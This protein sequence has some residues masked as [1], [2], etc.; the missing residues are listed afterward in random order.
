MQD[1]IIVKKPPLTIGSDAVNQVPVEPLQ[2]NPVEDQPKQTQDVDAAVTRST[3]PLG[4]IFLALFI[5]LC[6]ISATI[7][8]ALNQ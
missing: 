1:D 6:L 3:A 5:C 8:A 2:E 7:Y 4:V